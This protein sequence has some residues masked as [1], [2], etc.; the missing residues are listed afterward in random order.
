MKVKVCGLTDGNNIREIENAGADWFGFIFHP[1]SPRF[2]AER[3]SYLP[4]KG[5]RVGVFVNPKIESVVQRADDF[6]LHIVQ[7]YDSSPAFCRRIKNMGL[8]VVRA[9]PANRDLDEAA[10]PFLEVA[11]YLLFDTPSLQYG[12]TGKTYPWT[13][14]NSYTGALPF[15]LSGG[16]TPDAAETIRSIQH[17]ALAAVDI[18]SRFETSPGIKNAAEVARFINTLKQ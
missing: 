8:K 7:L 10:A 2:V 11:D 9:L 12:G 13:W 14:L 17:T 3:P 18:N 15:I 4:L 1:A 6:G 16:I 5:I